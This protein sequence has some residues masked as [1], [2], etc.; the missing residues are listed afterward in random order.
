MK[1]FLSLFAVLI[2]AAILSGC[3]ENAAEKSARESN[4]AKMKEDMMKGGGPGAA[5]M[6]QMKPMKDAADQSAD[7]NKDDADSGAKDDKD[8]GAGEK[9]TEE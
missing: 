9:E 6:K 8:E 2:C 7:E 1:R 4:E 5:M 3:G